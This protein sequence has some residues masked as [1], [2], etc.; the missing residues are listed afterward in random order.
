MA[1]RTSAG[2]RLASRSH[3]RL[4]MGPTDR[5]QVI[6]KR[7]VLLA[8]V[9]LVLA[10]VVAYLL[11]FLGFP[12]ITSSGLILA[13]LLTVILQGGLWLVLHLDLDR[14]LPWD[15]HYVYAP[16]IAFSFL[17]NLYIYLM[18]SIR[19]VLLMAWF[20]SPVFMAGLVGFTGMVAL[21]ALMATGYLF[22]NQLLV[23]SGEPV[24]FQFEAAVAMLFLLIN[25]YA[26][27]VFER[28]RQERDERRRLREKLAE[29]AITDPLTG[30]YNR[31][32]FEE[33]LRS[34]MAR[35]RRYGGTCSLAMIDLDFFKNYND[36]LGHLAGDD[37]LRELAALLRSHVRVSDVLAR[38]GGEEFA[39]V[40][41]NTPKEEAAR[42]TERLRTLVEAYPFRGGTI[43][44][45][46][47]LTVS[48]G[49][50]SCPED[51]MDYEELVEK[52]DAALYAAK[53]LGRNQVQPA[54][55]A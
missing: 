2:T 44:P 21:S 12:T 55:V 20:S 5:Q 37:L 52:A 31:R 1:T 15:P 18:P 36:T 11:N 6:K 4:R 3:L 33:I 26:G 40:M 38:Y 49:I 47:R 54:V 32:H 7:G 19:M 27:V 42:A 41:V 8:G 9:G 53:R 16:M 30:L 10:L 34:E 50:A 45:N 24:T 48:V 35:I 25:I 17:L 22:T 29:L 14:Y 46:G 39:L 13:L 28:L 51:G 43:Q 23:L